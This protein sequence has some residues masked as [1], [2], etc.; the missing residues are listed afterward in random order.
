MQILSINF[1][2]LLNNLIYLTEITER[3]VY[4]K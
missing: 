1:Y 2:F 3:N 4:C